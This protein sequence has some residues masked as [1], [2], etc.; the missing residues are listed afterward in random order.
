M[1]VGYEHKPYK[2]PPIPPDRNWKETENKLPEHDKRVE[3]K[4]PPPSWPR[5][6]DPKTEYSTKGRVRMIRRRGLYFVPE[7]WDREKDDKTIMN[8]ALP[9]HYFR[10]W[11]YLN[12]EEQTD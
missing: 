4:P 11:R 3:I 1:S 2:A 6:T 9:F 7:N 12:D 10:K 5:A 8:Y